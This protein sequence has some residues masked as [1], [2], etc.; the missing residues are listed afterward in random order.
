MT[1]IPATVATIDFETYCEAG[2]Y[3]DP[4]VQRWR[5]LIAGKPSIKGVGAYVYASHPSLDVLC[6]QYAFDDAPP[7]LWTPDGP[8][9]VDLLTHV[10]AGGAV[11]AHNAEFEIETWNQ[12]CVTRYGWPPLR[13]EQVSCS[14]AAATA[15]GLPGA[16]D[17]V[18]AIINPDMPKDPEGDRLL[19]KFSTPRSPTKHDKRQRIRLDP[20]DPDTAALYSY[21]ATDVRAE[22]GI[23]RL[24]PALSPFE[25]EI[26]VTTV[27]INQR[28]VAIDTEA[29]DNALWILRE[30]KNKYN[31]ELVQLTGGQVSSSDATDQMKAFAAS[32]GVTLPNIQKSTVDEYLTHGGLPGDVARVL[33]IRQLLSLSSLAKMQQIK[34]RLT[35]DGRIQGLFVYHKAH[36]GRWSGAGPQPQNLPSSGP[37]VGVC[38]ACEG[39]VQL[40]NHDCFFGDVT[41][42]DWTLDASLA[43]H[44]ACASR[45]LATVERKFPDALRAISGS[46]RALFIAA[47][48]HELICS[49]YSAIEAVVLAELA[50]ELWRQEVFRTHGK[51]YEMCASKITGVPFEEMLAH[52]RNTGN[53]HPHRKP[54]G[55][56]PELASGYGGWIGAWKRF[57]ADKFFTDDEIRDKILAWRADS[58]AIVEFW[59]K[60]YRETGR[61]TFR[62][63]FYGVEGAAICAVMNPGKW[64]HVRYVSF[65][66]LD[67]MLYIRL[68]SGRCLHYRDPKLTTVTDAYSKLSILQLSY[69]GWNSNAAEGPVGWHRRNTYGGRLV[70]NI[71]QAVARDI[72]AWGLV[73]ANRG[74][75][76]LVLHVHDELVSETEIGRKSIEGL[77]SHMGNL[78]P[79]CRGWPVKAAGGWRGR[80]YRKD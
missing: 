32:R 67:N 3:F 7:T 65:I 50:G 39:I 60:Q 19:R 25:R 59:G 76:P 54:Y 1:T 10:A 31:F 27:E 56:I 33:E 16:L 5:P 18:A 38:T 20:D 44:A 77:E 22:R 37:P 4:V 64:Y 40:D 30:A 52:K 26:W 72:M 48:G 34:H 35:H 13:I 73:N 49:D 68:P 57:G 74:G 24:L 12:H 55:K 41:P 75:Y 11:E 43:V 42:V 23:S 14:A 78:P 71:T 79:W 62:R 9:P 29:L 2:Y 63:E 28:G 15:Q 80:H 46:L 61:Y 8:P 66:R 45:N 6:L 17:K 47:D 21:C 36:T 53:S 70:E 51:I 58:P 69:M